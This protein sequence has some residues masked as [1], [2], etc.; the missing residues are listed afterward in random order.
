VNAL[1]ARAN[2]DSASKVL[3]IGCGT[4]QLTRDLAPTNCEIVCLEPSTALAVYARRNL[5]LFPRVEVREEFFES[6]E[7]AAE[8]F[9]LLVAATSFHWVDPE[10]RCDR[11]RRALRSGGL[12]AILTHV[13]AG[14]LTGFFERVQDVY[15]A[16][17]PSMLRSDVQG[18]NRKW[19]DEI[20][21][22]LARGRLFDPLET[23][24]EAWS[25]RISRD[26]YLS[27]LETFSSHRQLPEAQ[28]TRLF[29]EIGRIIDEEFGGS[30]EH[31]YLT[32]LCMA[33]AAR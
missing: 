16:I 4:G 22:E 1:I 17:A 8:T 7:V 10:T 2:L 12:I 5:L 27:L 15:G 14:R 28:R 19:S 9:D 23:I 29:T 26:Q 32:T 21:A 13:H 18:E 20:S 24:A 33:R 30:I 25:Q 31:P 3:E 6:F 11:A